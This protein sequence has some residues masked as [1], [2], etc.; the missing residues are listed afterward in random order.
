M[1]FLPGAQRRASRRRVIGVKAA[2]AA[3]WAGGS[4]L[5]GNEDPLK[6]LLELKRICAQTGG[7]A[8]DLRNAVD[9]MDQVS[10][11][12]L[13]AIGLVPSQMRL[14]CRRD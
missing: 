1:H 4:R 11:K 13:D 6:E 3:R 7:G 12:L 10:K 5:L 2:A 9:A 8:D 14:R